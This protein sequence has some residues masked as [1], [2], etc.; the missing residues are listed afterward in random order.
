MAIDNLVFVKSVCCKFLL[1]Q[2]LK[3]NDFQ[4]KLGLP[5]RLFYDKKSLSD[6]APV[7]RKKTFAIFAP[8]QF[9]SNFEK[10]KSDNLCHIFESVT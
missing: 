3:I 5:I 4:C 6:N 9:N 7:H 10:P 1:I 8:E 2:S